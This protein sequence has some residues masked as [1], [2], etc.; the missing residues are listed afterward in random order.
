MTRKEL[1]AALAKCEGHTPGPWTDDMGDIKAADDSVVATV[2]GRATQKTTDANIAL[3]LLAPA[4]VS[5][6]REAWA[7]IDRLKSA[8]L[9]EALNSGDGRE[10]G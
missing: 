8:P 2:W 7:E 4:L 1:E 6:L 10:K 5:A 9:D 3:L